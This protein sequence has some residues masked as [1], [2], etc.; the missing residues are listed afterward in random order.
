MEIETLQDS[1]NFKT[2]TTKKNSKPGT[3]F[4]VKIEKKVELQRLMYSKRI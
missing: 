2:K 4:V 1:L 3:P